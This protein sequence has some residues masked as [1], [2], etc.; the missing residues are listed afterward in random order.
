[1]S[2]WPRFAY[3]ISNVCETATWVCSSHDRW[4]CVRRCNV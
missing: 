4:P 2:E 3:V 1:M